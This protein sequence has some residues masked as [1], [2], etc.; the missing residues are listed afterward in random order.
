MPTT[1]ERRVTFEPLLKK[2]EERDRIHFA[3]KVIALSTR[4]KEVVFVRFATVNARLKVV[5]RWYVGGY[6]HTP[7]LYVVLHAMATVTA[8]MILRLIEANHVGFHDV[9]LCERT[10]TSW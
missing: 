1:M 2:V 3:A 7:N 10:L 8:T 5:S 9:H 4:N 6:G